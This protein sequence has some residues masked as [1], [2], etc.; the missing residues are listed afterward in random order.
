MA[1][2]IA[3]LVLGLALPGVSLSQA[4]LVMEAANG[5]LLATCALNGAP[6]KFEIDYKGSENYVPRGLV[7][8]LAKGGQI[9]PSN[10]GG[11]QLP[12]DASLEVS[13]LQLYIDELRI[14]SF[15][16]SG[17]VFSVS[18]NSVPY[19]TL[20]GK[21]L[22]KLGV[23][24]QK[25]KVLSITDTKN[26]RSSMGERSNN[27]LGDTHFNRGVQ[28]FNSG[29]YEAAIQDFQE[30]LQQNPAD[31]VSMINAGIAALS[32][33]DYENSRK[34]HTLALESGVTSKSA[35]KKPAL[36]PFRARSGLSAGT[37]LGAQSP[38]PVP[39]RP[40]IQQR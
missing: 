24:D 10:L 34:Y 19:I 23:V 13:K 28:N 30:A 32:V 17:V 12:L 25:G 33:E 22:E 18:S 11:T 16:I 36:H 1:K 8:M 5:T 27:E 35:Y 21:T 14:D 29:R 31:T 9:T 4:V 38:G 40:W 37:S 3:I 39:R 15:S 20:A 6:V 2:S 7:N 26:G